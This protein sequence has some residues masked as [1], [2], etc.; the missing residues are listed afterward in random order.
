MRHFGVP[1]SAALAA[2]AVILAALLVGC[3]GTVIDKNKLDDTTQAS[4]ERSLHEKIKSV[5]CPSDLSVDPGSTFECKVVFPDGK[6]ESAIL[7]IR[8]K[9]ADVSIVGLKPSQ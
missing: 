2:A 3:G 6:R 8:N 7:K 4:L 1:T 9:D 5:D